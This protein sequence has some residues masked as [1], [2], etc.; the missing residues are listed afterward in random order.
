MINTH[1]TPDFMIHTEM[2]SVID[3]L[4]IAI[5]LMEPNEEKNSNQQ[6]LTV[7]ASDIQLDLLIIEIYDL[8]DF[9]LFLHL[10]FFFSRC[11][12]ERKTYTHTRAYSPFHTI[13]QCCMMSPIRI[14]RV[15]PASASVYLC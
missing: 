1:R 2:I 15:S 9:A 11:L 5:H 3:I 6:R 4:T 8:S 7:R 14:Y 10:L 13:C 12:I